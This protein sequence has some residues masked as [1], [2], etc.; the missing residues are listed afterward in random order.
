[1][2][3]KTPALPAKQGRAEGCKRQKNFFLLI[4]DNLAKL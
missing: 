4:A 3:K 2:P 1:M